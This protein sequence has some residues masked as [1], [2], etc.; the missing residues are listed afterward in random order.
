MMSGAMTLQDFADQLGMMQR[1]G[2][3]TQLAQYIPGMG[4]LK[5]S[6]DQLAQGEV[7]LRKFK[8]ALSSMTRKERSNHKILNGSRKIRIA[9]GAGI[10]V[11]DIDRLLARF[12]QSQH[13]VKMMKRFGSF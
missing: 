13:F 2:S 9:H 12:E 3:L 5:V 1:L 8:A 7:E 11:E 4:N 10:K 6:K